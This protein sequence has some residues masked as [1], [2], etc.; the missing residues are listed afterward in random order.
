MGMKSQSGNINRAAQDAVY[1]NYKRSMVNTLSKRGVV[2]DTVA[3]KEVFE[4]LAYYGR[5]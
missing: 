4:A 3:Q 1:V 2:Y 5:L